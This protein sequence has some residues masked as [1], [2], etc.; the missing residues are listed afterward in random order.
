MISRNKI[1]HAFLVEVNNYD[2]D[3]ECVLEFVKKILSVNEKESIISSLVDSGNYPDL[4]II[5]PDGSVIKKNQL[6]K[7]QEEFRSKSFLNNKL[8]YIIKEADK[9]NDASGNTILKFLEEPEDEIIAI[10]V[11]T[12]RYK[13][14]ETILSRCQ[15]I[16]L[17]DDSIIF[18]ISDNVLDLLKFITKRDGL[19]INYQYII[20]N[21]MIDKNQAKELFNVIEYCLISYLNYLSSLDGEKFN[22]E[23]I[24]ILSSVDMD[25]ILSYIAIIEEE[26]QKLEYNVNYKLWLDCIFA[27]LI[28][29]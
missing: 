27:R 21:I 23:V 18:E 3:F 17:Q 1:S 11:T 6:I 29:G 10:L 4:K 26:L 13:V 24:K 7:L 15:I 12:N 19:F 9:L 22:S 2:D 8:I 14:I 25:K 20:S 16:S 5:E 28:G